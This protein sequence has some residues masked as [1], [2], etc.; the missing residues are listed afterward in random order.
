[1]LGLGLTFADA[2][3]LPVAFGPAPLKPA[4]GP[5][6]SSEAAWSFESRIARPMQSGQKSS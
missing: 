2:Q 4:G 6:T 1:M 5:G 3:A